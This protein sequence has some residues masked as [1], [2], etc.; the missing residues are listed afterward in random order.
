MAKLPFK[1]SV[2]QVNKHSKGKGSNGPDVVRDREVPFVAGCSREGRKWSEV[3]W[4]R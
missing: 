4:P 2:A 1:G 3:R